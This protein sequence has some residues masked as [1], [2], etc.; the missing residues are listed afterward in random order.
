MLK[1]DQGGW[2]EARTELGRPLRKLEQES[3]WD[4]MFNC[5]KV[6]MEVV[7]NHR[8]QDSFWIGLKGF[9]DGVDRRHER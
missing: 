3:R 5:L 2:K 9:A 6:A 7:K 1:T 8:I 4:I